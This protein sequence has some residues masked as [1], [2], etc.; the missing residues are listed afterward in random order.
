M[1]LKKYSRNSFEKGTQL[2]ICFKKSIVAQ[3]ATTPTPILTITQRLFN[4]RSI[5]AQ[6][7]ASSQIKPFPVVWSRMI[8]GLAITAQVATENMFNAVFGSL[9]EN[10][11][12][13]TTQCHGR[14]ELVWRS[15]TF[16]ICFF[17][18]FLFMKQFKKNRLFHG[19]VSFG[20]V[21]GWLFSISDFPLICW[22]SPNQPLSEVQ[23]RNI[24]ISRFM[25]AVVLNILAT[26]FERREPQCVV[27][28]FG[29]LEQKL[30]NWIVTC[31]GCGNANGIS[32][33][34]SGTGGASGTADSAPDE[35]QPQR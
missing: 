27:N 1:I 33:S 30:P 12:P 19:V 3:I 6:N 16:V 25:I 14:N 20:V 5:M 24:S 10:G 11:I 18:G 4:V 29:R 21:A 7:T 32:T 34:S 31:W 23:A 17:F 15:V 9:S 28:F 8:P 26:G 22:I 35:E 13:T 2:L